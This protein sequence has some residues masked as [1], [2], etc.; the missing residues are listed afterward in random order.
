VRRRLV[1]ALEQLLRSPEKAASL[2]TKNTDLETS[3]D[4]FVFVVEKP[5]RW[6]GGKLRALA[7]A[8]TDGRLG[9]LGLTPTGREIGRQFSTQFPGCYVVSVE[10]PRRE[11]FN[12][13]R[14]G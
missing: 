3:Q 12:F 10:R 6:T 1:H 4:G 13:N 8:V 5:G 2:T 9:L 11:R 7:G 14:F